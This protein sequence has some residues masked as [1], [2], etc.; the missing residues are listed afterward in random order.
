MKIDHNLIES[1]LVDIVYNEFLKKGFEDNECEVATE[2]N[3]NK[4]IHLIISG[5][6]EHGTGFLNGGADLSITVYTKQ[7][8]FISHEMEISKEQLLINLEKSL[9]NLLT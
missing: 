8:D 1:K 4:E 9:K 5:T 7:G 6:Y 3:I 2:T